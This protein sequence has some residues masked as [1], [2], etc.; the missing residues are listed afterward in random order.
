MNPFNKWNKFLNRFGFLLFIGTLIIAALHLPI[1]IDTLVS[2]LLLLILIP[3]LSL[4][5]ERI[6]PHGTSGLLYYRSVRRCHKEYREAVQ[7]I[8]NG[9]SVS[10]ILYSMFTLFYMI[11]FFYILLKWTSLI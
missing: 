2:I 5:F 9:T 10:N 8:V 7:E 3:S 4:L 6:E 11:R 1:F